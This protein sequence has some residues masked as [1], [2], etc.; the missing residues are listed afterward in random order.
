M[1]S[2]SELARDARELQR[3]NRAAMRGATSRARSHVRRLLGRQRADRR[4][5][6]LRA[7]VA[8][9]DR[10][11]RRRA[12]YV[13]LGT[14]GFGRSDTR[15]RLREFFE[16]DARHVVLAALEA[17]VREGT[18]PHTVLAQAARRTGA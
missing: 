10:R 18:L 2:F 15:Q 9:A 16:V 6:R 12:R 13:T 17:L 11:V 3:W 5:H 7:R 8:A 1:T 14:D 4:R